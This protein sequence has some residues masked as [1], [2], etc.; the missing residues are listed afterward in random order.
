MKLFQT[1]PATKL[2][3]ERKIRD[4]IAGQL[5]ELARKRSELLLA[6]DL[7]PLERHDAELERLQRADRIHG[8]RME[9]LEQQQREQAHA[10]REQRK[11]ET[12]AGYEKRFADRV[13]AAER[14]ERAAAE[15]GESLRGYKET[16]EATFKVWPEDLFPEQRWFSAYFETNLFGL[17]SIARA[18]NIHEHSRDRLVDMV[19]R[20][21]PLAE[22]EARSAA[23]FLERVRAAELP[24]IEEHEEIA[25]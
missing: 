8:Q 18:L 6:D 14:V 9:A 7:A 19:R 1:D 21:E 25:A 24:E 23:T 3:Q 20:I 16:C 11:A 12:I 2:A 10:Q 13:A 4:N 15:F 5:A 22:R 17:G